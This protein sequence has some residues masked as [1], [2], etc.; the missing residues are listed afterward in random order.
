MVFL[1]GLII[2]SIGIA[3]ITMSSLGISPIS[4]I[5]NVLA[6]AFTKL[7]LGN[8]TILFSLLLILIQLVILGKN[9]RLDFGKDP[10]NKG[11]AFYMNMTEAF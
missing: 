6:L 11:I 9:F 10:A 5:P 7:T 2:N 8:F 4:S 1:I 3:V